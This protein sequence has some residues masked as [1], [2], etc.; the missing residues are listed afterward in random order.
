MTQ[1]DGDL[2]QEQ[3]ADSEH[4]D[5]FLADKYG[6]IEEQAKA[7]SEADSLRREMQS[8]RDRER[9]DRESLQ[10]QF[11]ALEEQIGALVQQQ[12]GQSQ[13]GFDP[14]SHPTIAAMQAA[15]DNGDALEFAVAYQQLQGLS[16]QTPT[17]AKSS[18]TEFD[19]ARVG[20]H[21]ATHYGADDEMRAKATEAIQN[22]AV[23][24]KQFN[25]VVDDPN[26]T[27]DDL[28]PIVETAYQLV[29]GG[30]V[31][32]QKE[33]S[34]AQ[35]QAAQEAARQRKIE[36]EG[37]TGSGARVASPDEQKDAWKRIMDQ[38]TGGIKLGP[39]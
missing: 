9:R 1:P 27:V 10:E 2:Q 31:A 36:Q 16:Q 4:P 37:I 22:N 5:W 18:L 20:D 11:S 25:T 13:N 7:Y 12:G 39:Q 24:L 33:T 35:Q 29:Q 17:E 6:S 38:E 23:L 21:V 19:V 26:A 3:P 8:E 28:V 15:M 32:E 14:R 30:Q 34:L